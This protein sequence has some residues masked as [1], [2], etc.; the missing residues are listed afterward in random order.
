[1]PAVVSRPTVRQTLSPSAALQAAVRA[2]R[3]LSLQLQGL[4]YGA[5]HTRDTAVL[6]GH[7]AQG[8]SDSDSSWEG[9]EEGAGGAERDDRSVPPCYKVRCLPV[10]ALNNDSAAGGRHIQNV[11]SS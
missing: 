1:M 8:G 2:A 10:L 5:L 4:G 9:E 11:I 6:A 7:D 3:A